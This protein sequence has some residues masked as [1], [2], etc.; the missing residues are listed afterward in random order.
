MIKNT[1]AV[2]VKVHKVE[3]EAVKAF[4]QMFYIFSSSMNTL[5]RSLHYMYM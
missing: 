1:E 2:E 4:P 3:A 5:G